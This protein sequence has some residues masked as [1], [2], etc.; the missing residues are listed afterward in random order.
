MQWAG[1]DSDSN[2]WV[3][4]KQTCFLP[5]G[6]TDSWEPA[7]N[8]KQCDRLLASFW[9]HVGTDDEDY[10]IG[11]E[12]AARED[13]INKEKRYFAETFAKP[14]KRKAE[15]AAKK[16]EKEVGITQQYACDIERRTSK[17]ATRHK[18]E[19]GVSDSDDSDEEPLVKR[20]AKGKTKSKALPD[21]ESESES[22]AFMPKQ[23]QPPLK[24]SS[25]EPTQVKQR[26]SVPVTGVVAP[27][28]V[29]AARTHQDQR[30]NPLVKPM[31][32]PSVEAG[33]S[34]STK[35]RIA[36]G[37]PLPPSGA[38]P[39]QALPPKKSLS[40]LSFK[41][42]KPP[43]S[44]SIQAKDSTR[45]SSTSVASPGTPITQLANVTDMVDMVMSPEPMEIDQP[46]DLFGTS[47]TENAG[48]SDGG[49]Q[50]EINAE[51]FLQTVNIP[52]LSAPLEAISDT[53]PVQNVPRTTE[54]VKPSAMPK[55]PKKW[56]WSGKLFIKSSEN[57]TKLLCPVTITDPTGTSNSSHISLL[58]SSQ[59]S[60]YI[61]SL[62][63]I[64]HLS[65]IIRAC[66]QPQYFGRLDS[67]DPGD[68]AAINPL[69][70]DGDEVAVLIVF[71]A[72]QQKLMKVLQVPDHLISG[73]LLLVVLLPFLVSSLK[74]SKDVGWRS[75]DTVL[76]SL[77][78][79]EDVE[80][81]YELPRRAIL[82][83]AVSLLR[84]P[85]S[86]LDFLNT[87]K[88][89]CIW[90]SP[91]PLSGLDTALLQLIL[92]S[93][94]GTLAGLED[95]VRVV[96]ICNRD[97]ET[98]PMMPSLVAKQANSPET[99]F[100]TYGYST[101]V[102]EHPLWHC[103]MI[104]EVLAASHLLLSNDTLG[105]SSSCLDPML[106][107]VEA[108]LLCVTK[109]PGQGH[110][111]H[112]AWLSQVFR[113]SVL[114]RHEQLGVYVATLRE[115]PTVLGMTTQQLVGYTNEEVQPALMDDYRRFVVIRAASEGAIPAEK[116]GFEWC[117][118]ASFSFKDDYFQ[119]EA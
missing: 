94:K 115:H 71:P 91:G 107:L 119:A 104:P 3:N 108:G 76:K 103:Y 97:M 109:M 116:D 49:V 75:M 89:Y 80:K 36:A 64:G 34:L 14:P 11:Y 112:S 114:A 10:P 69:L 96:F 98:L 73:T 31:N 106:D 101:N 117:P 63:P 52:L 19:R 50:K 44:I 67:N 56:K 37:I 110:S 29:L 35:H 8:V 27:P 68:Q 23:V 58:M 38:K 93:T 22:E 85:K 9:K 4:R 32:I 5:H 1:Y 82:S 39:L 12:V 84:F 61:S 81:V 28:K 6:V 2:R 111:N 59:D 43:I 41:K 13:W 70:L 113:H 54:P 87:S 16:K 47:F 100:W 118:L 92:K 17:A 102:I 55:I 105:L 42:N 99:Q 60:L 78:S 83:Q 57:E 46:A 77:S 48:P 88:A 21:T 26:Q 40:S 25:K 20:L 90:P 7:E 15:K 74:A 79:S 72:S 53:S 24:E 33:S 30:A 62:Y 51:R 95:D 65:P 45:M 18:P 66:G 86:L